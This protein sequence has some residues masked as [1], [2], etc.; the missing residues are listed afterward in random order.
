LT[1]SIALDLTGI[2]SLRPV[3]VAGSLSRRLVD[4]GSVLLQASPT[5]TS[6]ETTAAVSF[7][8]HCIA[9]KLSKAGIRHIGTMPDFVHRDSQH[10]AYQFNGIVAW[11]HILDN[12]LNV[13]SFLTRLTRRPQGVR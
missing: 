13:R 10:S 7:R 3:K 11:W 4:G 9:R 6:P 5:T 2:N 1:T 12:F 8:F